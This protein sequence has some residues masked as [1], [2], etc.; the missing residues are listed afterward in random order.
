[1]N[2]DIMRDLTAHLSE[3]L[4]AVWSRHAYKVSSGGCSAL[5]VL[6]IMLV[7][8]EVLHM[9]SLSLLAAH[10]PDDDA[11]WVLSTAI[12]NTNQNLTNRR[13]IIHQHASSA[14]ASAMTGQP[15]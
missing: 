15:S 12:E 13:D 11:D 2:K 1:M 4:A 5:E 8:T 6:M 3:D 7:A 14:K 9:A 10:V